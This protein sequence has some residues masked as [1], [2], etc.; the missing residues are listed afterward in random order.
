[1]VNDG[2]DKAL[3]VCVALR[4]RPLHGRAYGITLLQVQIIT[5]ADLIPVAHNRHPGQGEQHGVAQG[6][7]L[8]VA[9][10][11]RREAT[12]DPSLVHV[13]LFVRGER[14]EDELFILFTDPFQIQFVVVTQPV[15]KAAGVR[16]DDH[17][18]HRVA[19][20]AGAFSGQ[21][22]VEIFVE[23]EIE[24]QIQAVV[25]A[26]VVFV[27]LHLNIHFTEQDRLRVMLR[28]QAT[29]MFEDPQPLFLITV[30]G[31]GGKMRRRVQAKPRNPELKPENNDVLNLFDHRR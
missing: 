24:D 10:Q 28:N 16:R 20:R 9:V 23:P 7:P 25:V 6:Q 22:D 13:H 21:A 12:A 14:I 4:G 17:F 19:Q 27:G 15:G 18:L 3:R 31:L 30:S 26:E 11:H 2:R 5:H 29:Q 1:M 8:L